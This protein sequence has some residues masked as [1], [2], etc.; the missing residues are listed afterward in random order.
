VLVAAQEQFGAN[1]ERAGLSFQPLGAPAPEDWMPLMG[2]FAELDFEVAHATMV[3]EFFAGLDVAAALPGLTECVDRWSPDLI[4]RETWEFASTVVAEA[5]GIPIARVALGLA[6]VEDE[7]ARIAA[8]NVDE[9]RRKLGLPADPTGERLR[10]SPGL[11]MV[12]EVLEDP[13]APG[14]RHRFRYP[15]DTKRSVARDESR[16]EHD[17]LVYLTFGSVAAGSHLPYYPELFRAAIAALARL[18]VRLLV[19]VGDADRDA[20]E[21]GALPGNVTVET[22]VRHDDVARAADVVVCHGGF[23]STLGTLAHGTPLVVVPVFSLDQWANGEAAARSGAGLMLADDPAGRGSLDLP[24]G[25]V[26]DALAATV[27]RVL[28][29]SS[30]R[31]AAERVARS[32]GALPSVDASV[33]LLEGLAG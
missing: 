9:A 22:W 23:G 18:P 24:S 5:R 27:E 25:D 8:A 30:Y 6:A 1:V 26:V 29:E 32:M 16:P 13:S 20:A 10:A 21:L 3:G 28:T 7:S 31:R 15:A 11:T 19:T 17:P 4:V 2:G 14:D 33:G 12:P